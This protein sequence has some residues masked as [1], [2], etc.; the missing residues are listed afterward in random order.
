[1]AGRVK[2][3]ARPTYPAVAASTARTGL[4]AIAA[5]AAILGLAVVWAAG[6][7]GEEPASTDPP[8][9]APVT[10]RGLHLANRPHPIADHTL[11]KFEAETGVKV[12]YD[13]Y[14]RDSAPDRKIAA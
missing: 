11:V 9:A 2:R 7:P 10:A 12:E 13:V 4:P 8:I 1:M 3:T 5:A 14:A 6:A